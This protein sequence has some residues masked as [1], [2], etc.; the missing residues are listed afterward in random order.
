[1][2]Q[3]LRYS[4]RM[5]RN[6]PAF[7]AI[8]ILSLA[9]GI[10]ANTAVFSLVDSV[11]LKTLP[12]QKPDQLVLFRWV[13]GEKTMVRAFNGSLATDKNAGLSSSISFSYPAFE[14]LRDHNNTLSEMFGF[15]RLEQLNV[16]VD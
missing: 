12:V 11:L 8:A 9:L 6:S 1:M 10:G 3:D 16:N 7:S 15:A 14:Y 4:L 13:S 2:L 5:L